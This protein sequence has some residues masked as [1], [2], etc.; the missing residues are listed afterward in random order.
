[1]GAPGRGVST[2]VAE[3]QQ[4]PKSQFLSRLGSGASG[5]RAA[6]GGGR[7][8]LLG[9]LR[10]SGAQAVA[11]RDQGVGC[12]FDL[13]WVHSLIGPRR[14]VIEDRRIV[15]S[16]RTSGRKRGDRG[17]ER[18]ARDDTRCHSSAI[19]QIHSPS[20]FHDRHGT[21]YAKSAGAIPSLTIPINSISYEDPLRRH[22][23][24]FDSVVICPNKDR[25]GY[26]TA[27]KPPMA[28]TK[29]P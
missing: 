9:G 26:A 1:M 10:V 16:R 18:Q 25:G 14:R 24:R 13:V 20:C 3:L 5:P 6:R 11:V 12:L 2:A 21:F 15:G 29:C 17:A 27:L 28:A 19:A 4:Y 23:S 22:P 8:G 7:A